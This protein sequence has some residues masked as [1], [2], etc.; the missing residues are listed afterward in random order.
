MLGRVHV[1]INLT[2]IDLQVE[3][4]GGVTAVVQHIAV[5]LLDRVGNQPVPDHPAV[6]E[7][8]LQIRLAAGECGQAH[9][10]PEPKIGQVSFNINCLFHK[11]RATDGGHPALLFGVAAAG[12]EIVNDLAVMAQAEAHVKA[13]QCQPFDHL[14]EVIELGFFS[15]QELPPGRG[16][17]EQVADFHGGA[18]GM[19]CGPNLHLHVA[20]LGNGR[21]ALAAAVISIGGQGQPR[22]RADTGQRFAAKPQAAHPF[23]VLQRS[24][25][26]GGVA[27]QRQRQV[28]GL[29]A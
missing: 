22:Y 25:L 23:K 28:L 19:R 12:L 18:L 10:A 16:I 3:Y 15:A 4:K 6:D 9:P 20:A 21:A 27:G 8:I 14:L 26:A 7:E 2:R 5:G 17:E 13:R 24:Y 11:R 29:H 1:D